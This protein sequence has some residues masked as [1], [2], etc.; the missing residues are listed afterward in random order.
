[1]PIVRVVAEPAEFAQD[2]PR[3]A[4]PPLGNAGSALANVE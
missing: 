2:N 4:L 3:R 1:M